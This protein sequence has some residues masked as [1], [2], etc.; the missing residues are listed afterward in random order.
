MYGKRW[1]ATERSPKSPGA[2]GERAARAELSQFLSRRLR[3]YDAKRNDPTV[4]A[5]SNLSPWIH[6]GQLAS[7]RAVLEA[8]KHRSSHSK[9]VAGFVEEIVVRKELS[10]NF[11][12]YNPDGY[13]SLLTLYDGTKYAGGGAWA[14]KT[15]VEHH[16]DPREHVYTRDQ[17]ER[18]ETI[19]C[20][21]HANLRWFIPAKC[22]VSAHVLGEENI[23]WSRDPE[24]ALSTAIYLNDYEL[25]GRDPNGYVGCGGNRRA[26]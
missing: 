21:M 24:E 12:L 14:T 18:A 13:D 7:Q 20:G 15:L 1:Y 25:D 22:T 5:L 2:A 19:R 23:E 8:Q 17:W 10:D 9:S 4:E 6:F 26:A 16:S 3:L 11:C